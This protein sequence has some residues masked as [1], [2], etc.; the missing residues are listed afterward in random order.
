MN[1]VPL[2]LQA[3]SIS[4]P[5][6]GTVARLSTRRALHD[7]AARTAPRLIG[8][9]AVMDGPSPDAPSRLLSIT[10]TR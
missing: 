10:R 2:A 6:H 5:L 8:H 1:L 9:S 3:L 7:L 4:A